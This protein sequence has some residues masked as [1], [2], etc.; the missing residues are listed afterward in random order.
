MLAFIT[1]NYGFSIS[2]PAHSKKSVKSVKNLFR[3]CSKNPAPVPAFPRLVAKIKSVPSRVARYRPLEI[4][5]FRLIR[6]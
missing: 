6:R 2:V 1:I 5:K 3:L 4:R